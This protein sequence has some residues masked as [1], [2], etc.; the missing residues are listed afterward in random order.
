MSY[1]DVTVDSPILTG[2][3]VDKNTRVEST[4]QEVNEVTLTSTDFD[5]SWE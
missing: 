3:V 5:I 2:S 1:L 4:A